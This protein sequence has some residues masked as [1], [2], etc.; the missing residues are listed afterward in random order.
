MKVKSII[1]T[2]LAFASTAMPAEKL[3][4]EKAATVGQASAFAVLFKKSALSDGPH[5]I[6]LVNQSQAR[7]VLDA[8]N[9]NK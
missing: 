2:M 9:V 1:L 3:E 8:F 7:V 5:L 6:K 4:A